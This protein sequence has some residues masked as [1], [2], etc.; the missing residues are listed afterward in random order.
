MAAFGDENV[1]GLDVA[2]NDALGVRGV[3]A[4]GDV[5]GEGEEAF[6]VHGAA[7][8]G[9]LEGLAL[10]V[11]HRDEGLAVGVADFVDGADV[12]VVEGGGGFGFAAETFEGLGI[13]GERFG[14][15]FQSDETVEE[16]VLGFVDD[17]HSA[18]T[19]SFDDAEMRDGLSDER[20]WVG[21]GRG[22]TISRTYAKST[23]RQPGA[24]RV[25]NAQFLLTSAAH[26]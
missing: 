8:D 5:D 13:A 1:G 15:E 24:R 14:E 22:N 9:V 20:V 16:R 6:E 3:E 18:A 12:G 21:H 2:M 17:A 25:A 4:V 26:C 19:E 23:R 7:G 11:L 10:E